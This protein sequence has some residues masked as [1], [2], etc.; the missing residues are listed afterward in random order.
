MQTSA[1]DMDSS[2]I[3]IRAAL[4]KEQPG[5]SDECRISMTPVARREEGCLVWRFEDLNGLIGV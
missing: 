2:E 3:P 1:F 4:F 5:G